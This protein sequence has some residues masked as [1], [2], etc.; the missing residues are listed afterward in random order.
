MTTTRSARRA[1]IAAVAFT[2]AL[3]PIG[4]SH[5]QSLA[6][7]VAAVKSGRVQFTYTPREGVCG[8]G[9][10]FV[11]MGTHTYVGS[12][13]GDERFERSCTP[14]PVRVVARVSGGRVD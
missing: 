13:N 7:R 11:R 12:W 8:D 3:A 9:R 14:G 4:T 6:A 2:A 5:A 10:S 1:A